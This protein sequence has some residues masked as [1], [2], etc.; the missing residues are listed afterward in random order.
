LR[1]GIRDCYSFLREHFDPSDIRCRRLQLRAADYKKEVPETYRKVMSPPL[2]EKDWL[3]ARELIP[4]LKM[5][6]KEALGEDLV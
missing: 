1:R 3:Q 6:Y 4:E 5:R 2:D